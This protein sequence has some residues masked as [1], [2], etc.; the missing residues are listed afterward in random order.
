[1]KIINTIIHDNLLSF[2]SEYSCIEPCAVLGEGSI[3]QHIKME[4]T[5]NGDDISYVTY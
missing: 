1:M 4:W 2:L 5:T 3:W